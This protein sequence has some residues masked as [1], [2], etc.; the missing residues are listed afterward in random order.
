MVLEI[1][2]QQEPA[3]MISVEKGVFRDMDEGRTRIKKRSKEVS[4]LSLHESSKLVKNLVVNLLLDTN[5][6]YYIVHIQRLR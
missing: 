3:S 6:Y 2:N 1:P 5:V 4:S